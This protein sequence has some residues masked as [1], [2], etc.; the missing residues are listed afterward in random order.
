MHVR[1]LN[2]ALLKMYSLA[3]PC[4]C[5]VWDEINHAIVYQYGAY[6]TSSND[7]DT[8][9]YRKFKY[10]HCKSPL[11]SRI[12]EHFSWSEPFYHKIYFTKSLACVHKIYFTKSLAC[13][14]CSTFTS[15]F[16]KRCISHR[17]HFINLFHKNKCKADQL[18]NMIAR[19]LDGTLCIFLW[20]N[21]L[22]FFLTVSAFSKG[23]I[24]FMGYC[25]VSS[26]TKRKHVNVI[27]KEHP[28]GTCT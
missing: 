26:Q 24:F 12:W 23:T 4:L 14:L 25:L 17:Q 19:K 11:Y 7:D 13:V 16:L 9:V 8:T 27:V 6:A 3:S 1:R 2:D 15:C 5:T 28:Y 10:T 20:K 22:G 18:F 21:K